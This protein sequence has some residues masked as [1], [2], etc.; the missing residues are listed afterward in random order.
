MT[1]INEYIAYLPE[2]EN[3]SVDADE[4]QELTT[5]EVLLLEAT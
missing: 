3:R 2:K 1:P 5:E 4:R